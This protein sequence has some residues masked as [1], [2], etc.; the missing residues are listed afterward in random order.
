M[1]VYNVY[2]FVL[3]CSIASVSLS[4]VLFYAANSLLTCV[5]STVNDRVTYRVYRQTYRRE[6]NQP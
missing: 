3:S 2:A 6:I 1:N 4:G 5:Y